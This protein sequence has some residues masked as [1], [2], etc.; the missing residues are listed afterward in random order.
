MLLADPVIHLFLF[1]IVLLFVAGVG[2]TIVVRALR[3]IWRAVFGRPPRLDGPLTHVD[4]RTRHCPNP[5]C[6]YQN[7]SYARYCARC[8]RPLA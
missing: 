3:G 5:H 7:P 1:P 2:A 8:G 4:A 6:R